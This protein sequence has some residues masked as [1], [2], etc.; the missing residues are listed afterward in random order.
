LIQKRIIPV[1]L[2]YDGALVKTINF[3]NFNYIGDPV[4][5]V[6]IFNELQVDEIIILDI[7]ASKLFKKPDYELIKKIASECFIPLSFGGGIKAVSDI[8]NILSIGVEKV[9]INTHSLV[10]HTLITE[11]ANEFGKQCII[12]SVDYKIDPVT[13]KRYVFNHTNPKKNNKNPFNWVSDLHNSG[14]GEL[15]ITSVDHEGLWNG[16]DQGFLREISKSLEIPVIANG[17]AGCLEDISELFN[18]TFCTAAAASSLFLYQKKG[19]GVLVNFPEQKDFINI[20]K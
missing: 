12:G 18:K 8:H 16:Y 13:K 14:I 6:R 1:L 19:M 2:L 11:S 17:G 15:L 7:L 3:K 10:N 20:I 9:V 5:T 4:N